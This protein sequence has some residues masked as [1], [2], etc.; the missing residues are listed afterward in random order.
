MIGWLILLIILATMILL[1]IG[2]AAHFLSVYYNRQD[3]QLRDE[4]EAHRKIL[5]GTYDYIWNNI[6]QRAGIREEHRR[7]FNNIYPDLLNKS[8]DNENFLNWI[9]DC[10][11]DFDPQEY[12]PLLE[13]IVMARE[14][15]VFHQIRMENLIR[16]HRVLLQSKPAKWLIRDKSAIVYVPMETDYTRWGRAI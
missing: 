11:L 8:I 15:F 13:L 5:E 14:K 16:E 7:S 6:K 12:P 3:K 10:N 2:I 4:A 1:P 9:L